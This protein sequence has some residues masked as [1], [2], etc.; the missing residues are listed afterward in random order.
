MRDYPLRDS[1]AVAVAAAPDALFALLDDPTRLGAHM[2]RRSWRTAGM[3]MDY[4][5]DERRGQVVGAPIGLRGRLV[6]LRLNVD[7]VVIERD[8]PRRKV[9]ETTGAV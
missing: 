5:L 6:G 7:E 9:W 8:P 3:R 2:Q 1:V 4:V